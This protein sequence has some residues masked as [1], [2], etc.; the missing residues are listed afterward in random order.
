MS[1]TPR[2]DTS[3]LILLAL[4]SA[5]L[6]A[7]LGVSIASVLLPTLS[8]SFGASVSQVQWVVLAYL[9][10]MT[11]AIVSAGRL[12]DS[13]GHRRVLLGGLAVFVAGSAVCAAAPNLA[14]LVLGRAV[15]G[16]GSAI[17]FALPMSIA[18]NTVAPSRLG[19]S[20]GVI[21]T[22]SAVGTAL[23]PSVGG[24]LLTWGDWRLAFYLLAGAGIATGVVAA[25]SLR[26]DGIR[27]RPG[28]R[29]MDIPG[30]LLLM[31]AVGAYALAVSGDAVSLP[32][33]PAVLIPC[34]ALAGVAFA[35][36]ETRAASPLVPMHLLRN[37]K[38]GIGFATNLIV[39]TIMMSTLVVGPFYLTFALGLSDAMVGLVMATGPAI[40][41]VA[42]IPAGRLTD[43]LGAS[44]VVRIG[45]AQIALGLLCL[46]FL[47]R[48]FGV[49][50]YVVALFTLTPAFQ[51]FL[52]AN[53]TSV[54]FKA[55]PEQRGRLS[56]LLGLSR[57]L[58][59]MTGASLMPAV[60]VAILGT[61]DAAHAPG[62]SIAH[63]FSM[64]FTAAAGLA[65]LALA[66]AAVSTA[67]RTADGSEPA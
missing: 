1:D 23:G 67:G 56:G 30:T 39:G 59:L 45:L 14:W 18:R 51:L 42:G 19:T 25:S 57:N 17:L 27:K 47:P 40:A 5:T 3:P 31:I 34:T 63:A 7:A 46:A 24:A 58:G 22:M 2:S 66:L 29:E 10:S 50:G 6:T 16:L 62:D 38:T 52:A 61:G 64:T 55:A 41:S 15:Q 49:A 11:V 33:G 8:R 35:M 65:L 12:G 44:R 54:L 9:M 32:V 26:A 60:F 28:V 48:H 13:Y 21:A 36:I 20:M 43:R 4:A 53:N 37:R